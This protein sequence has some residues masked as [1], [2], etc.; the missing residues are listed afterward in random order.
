MKSGGKGSPTKS[1]VSAL[2]SLM[3]LHPL[4]PP[5]FPTW[6]EVTRASPATPEPSPPS[7]QGLFVSLVGDPHVLFEDLLRSPEKY[8]PEVEGLLLELIT[9]RRRL[10]DLPRSEREILDRATLDYNRKSSSSPPSPSPT[11]S[12]ETEKQ[13]TSSDD[14]ERPTKESE[15]EPEREIPSDL[16]PDEAMIPFWFR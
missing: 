8:E 12:S 3:Q 9:G 11:T 4:V 1:P 15:P 13:K 10:Q 7:Q 14:S 2:F 6:S 5:R 16:I